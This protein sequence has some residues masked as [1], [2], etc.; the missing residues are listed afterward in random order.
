MQLA[1]SSA[2][3]LEIEHTVRT[4]GASISDTISILDG[5]ISS[6]VATT[7]CEF[8]QLTSYSWKMVYNPSS[9]RFAG[10]SDL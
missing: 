9:V 6:G 4:C 5:K 2:P 7:N 3:I 1:T 10:R 8:Q